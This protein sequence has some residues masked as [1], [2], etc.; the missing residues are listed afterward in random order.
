MAFSRYLLLAAFATFL[1]FV[2]GDSTAI[3]YSYGVDFV[4]E[5]SYFINQ[6]L[7]EKFAAVSY[8]QGCNQ[9]IADVLLV[10]PEGVNSQEYLCDQIPTSVPSYSCSSAF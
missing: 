6:Q 7:T 4:D 9:D 5:G 10:E 2:H 8:F 3:C 1:S